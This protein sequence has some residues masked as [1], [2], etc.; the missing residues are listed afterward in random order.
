MGP[1]ETSALRWRKSPWDLDGKLALVLAIPIM[2]ARGVHL[3]GNS[4]V[5]N[6]RSA[7]QRTGFGSNSLRPAF[8]QWRTPARED[9]MIH[10]NLRLEV[11]GPY[12]VVAMRGTCLRGQGRQP[13]LPT[14]I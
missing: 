11:K 12:I 7:M 14:W 3:N 2:N 10:S 9:D 4:L 1:L 8:E 5:E 6:L 13:W